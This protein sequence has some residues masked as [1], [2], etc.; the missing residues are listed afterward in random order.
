MMKQGIYYPVS[1]VATIVE[2]FYKL[3]V[4]IGVEFEFNATA[5]SFEYSKG[6]INAV[7]C[8]N[9]TRHSAD[10]F[11][12]NLD[13]FSVQG[14]LQRRC[15]VQ[16]SFSYFTI[17]WGLKNRISELSHH[18]LVIPLDFEVGFEQLY[19]GGK[20]P[21][22]P[23]VYLNETTGI[24]P[25]VAPEG[26]G[27][28]FAVVT[29]PAQ[30]GIWDWKNQLN[31]AQSATQS[32]MESAG[33]KIEQENVVIEQVQSPLTFE[34]RDGN[35]KGS[36]YGEADHER[37]FLGLPHTNR[38]QEYTNLFYCGGSVQPGAGL[39]MAC[40][41]GKFAVEQLLGTRLKPFS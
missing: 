1:G 6:R 40:L 29:A 25:Q 17:Q 32:V 18:N 11:I 31:E 16:P 28:L 2:A 19:R 5:N 27:N 38:D 34:K 10:A 23:I 8:S 12:S 15:T 13:F 36:L 30:N 14:L 35:Y 21:T 9:G 22:R 37:G 7:R 41:S 20:F 4:D 24:D 39:P 3:A 26:C 33:I